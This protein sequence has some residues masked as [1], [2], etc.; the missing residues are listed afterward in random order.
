MRKTILAAMAALMILTML[1]GCQLAVSS[2]EMNPG[3]DR[4]CGVF[5][6]LDYIDISFEDQEIELP[7]NWNGDSGNIVFPEGRIY[8]TRIEEENG[9]IDYTFDGIEG[10]RLFSVKTDS[11]DGLGSYS[12][13]FGDDALQD[14]NFSLS[15]EEV[16]ISGTIYYDVHSPLFSIFANPVYQT[17]DGQVYMTS[18]SGISFGGEQSEGSGGSTS[19]SATTT[20]TIDGE[21]TSHTTKVE[22]KIKALNTN[23]KVVLKQMDGDDEIIA[24]TEFTQDDIPES[25]KIEKDTAYMI[26]EEHCIDYENK[27]SVKRKL[28][29]T[30]EETLGASFT[31]D[32][33]IVEAHSVLLKRT[34]NETKS[35]L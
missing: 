26:M 9:H 2:E 13:S 32:N 8:A 4:L 16:N 33:G 3:A 6:T 29:K 34:G 10:F 14:G 30:D 11:L 15:D 27:P 31:G 17:P 24:Q 18:G 23:K 7:P 20:E 22:I 5:V 25:I 35:V 12:S 19:L 21:E 1:G 28:V